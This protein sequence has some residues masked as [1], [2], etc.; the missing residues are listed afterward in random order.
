VLH[1]PSLIADRHD[2]VAFCELAHL[3]GIVRRPSAE[4]AINTKSFTASLVKATARDSR[5]VW[6]CFVSR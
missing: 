3:Q 6:D 2:N 5:A 4:R 1:H